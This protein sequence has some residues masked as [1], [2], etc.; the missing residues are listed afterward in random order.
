MNP[1]LNLSQGRPNPSLTA[2]QWEVMLHSLGADS[3]ARSSYCLTGQP[4]G[5]RDQI[6][7]RD[8]GL[9]QKLKMPEPAAIID[10]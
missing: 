7:P 2:L 8:T 1:S 10:K 6:L 9:T 3:G 4:Q 5:L